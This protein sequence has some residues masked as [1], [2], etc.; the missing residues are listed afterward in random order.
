MLVSTVVSACGVM[1]TY[2]HLVS[3]D[4]TCPLAEKARACF[5]S[6]QPSDV[7]PDD[8]NDEAS[9]SGGGGENSAGAA[10]DS[11]APGM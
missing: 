4:Q 8:N 1:N 9:A 2:T 5:S 6:K 11:D 10:G 3:E 7:V